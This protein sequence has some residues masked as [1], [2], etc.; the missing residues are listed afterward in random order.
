MK[1]HMLIHEMLRHTK[2]TQKCKNGNDEGKTIGSKPKCRK[3]PWEQGEEG[4]DNKVEYNFDVVEYENTAH[5]DYEVMSYSGSHG[6]GEDEDAS[7]RSDI[8]LEQSQGGIVTT[9]R[10]KIE[11]L[12]TTLGAHLGRSGCIKHLCSQ[13]NLSGV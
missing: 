11:T 1:Q 10:K 9:E 13:S 7:M 3:S 8:N 5:T 12:N 6:E 2:L 4:N